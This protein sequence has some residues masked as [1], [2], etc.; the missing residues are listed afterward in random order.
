MNHHDNYSR[1]QMLRDAEEAGT[2]LYVALLDYPAIASQ[3][4]NAR[5]DALEAYA[6]E[7]TNAKPLYPHAS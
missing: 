2:E 4:A 3:E 5:A 7:D 6:M 1:S